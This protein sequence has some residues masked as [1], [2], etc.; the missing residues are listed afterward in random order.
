M[1]VL[2]IE[3][4]VLIANYIKYVLEKNEY[5][6][7]GIADT[8]ETVNKSIKVLCPDIALLDIRLSGG[9]SGIDISGVLCKKDIPFVYL[10]ANSD[11]ATMSSAL[12]TNPI[13]YITKPFNEDNVIAAIELLRQ[14]REEEQV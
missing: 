6:V 11:R 13:A 2:I 7:T 5:Y 14:G 1:K 4:D 9:E 8:T 10:T 3:D 12:K